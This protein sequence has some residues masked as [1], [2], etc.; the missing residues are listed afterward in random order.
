ML[1]GPFLESGISVNSEMFG[2]LPPFFSSRD[3]LVDDAIFMMY[4]R[5]PPSLS[6]VL[7]FCL[8]SL[9]Y[10]ADWLKQNLPKSH[11]IF[12]TPLFAAPALLE[13]LKPRV[14]CGNYK[15]GY[16]IRPTGVPPQTEDK[17]KLKTIEEKVDVLLSRQDRVAADV[18]W[19]GEAAP[20]VS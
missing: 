2:I 17:I 12:H 11:L 20:R 9:V 19:S 18:R 8:A 14:T 13:Q 5:A 6:R 3:Q 16:P 15:I 7:E 4:P 1:A 10:H